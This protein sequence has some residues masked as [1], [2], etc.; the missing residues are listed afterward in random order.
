MNTVSIITSPC[1]DLRYIRSRGSWPVDYYINR[2]ILTVLLHYNMVYWS[3][4]YCSDSRENASNCTRIMA[5]WSFPILNFL[6]YWLITDCLLFLVT[7]LPL[8]S[9]GFVVF[10]VVTL[11][12]SLPHQGLQRPLIDCCVHTLASDNPLELLLTSQVIYGYTKLQMEF[13]SLTRSLNE[14]PCHLNALAIWTALI[15]MWQITI[16]L[17]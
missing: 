4:R 17:S 1:Y 7:H 12:V 9:T 6:I 2:L 16:K 5:I 13:L 14:W 10:G 8:I 3:V 11:Q 15:C